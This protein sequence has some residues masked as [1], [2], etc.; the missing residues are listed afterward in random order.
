[1]LVLKND[2]ELVYNPES[3]TNLFQQ[4][5]LAI[6]G[7]PVSDKGKELVNLPAFTRI[8]PHFPVYPRIFPY[9]PVYPRIYPYLSIFIYFVMN[10]VT[11]A[12]KTTISN[13]FVNFKSYF[14]Q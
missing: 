14:I 1:M 13:E 10:Y 2:N 6:V 12:K 4:K 8:S 5:F 7:S 9:I 11:Y 3:I